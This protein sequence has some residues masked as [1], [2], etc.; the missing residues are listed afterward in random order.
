MRRPVLVR[1]L[2]LAPLALLVLAPMT[3]CTS[4]ADAG[5]GGPIT[6]TA[7]DSSCQLSATTADTGN[8]TF[9]VTN[10]GTKTTEFYLY[11]EGNR[12]MGE[13][14]NVSPGLTRRLVVEVP[15]AGAYTTAC[16]PGMVGEGVRGTFT[17]TGESRRQVDA[18]TKLADA[19]A[20]YQ[21]Y[22]AT[23]SDALVAKTTEFTDAV[24]AG[25]VEQAKA[26]YPVA[27]TFW[28]RIEPVAEKFGELDAL[29]DGRE[30]T[31]APGQ[32]LTGWHR[33]ERDLWQD[34]L[35]PDSSAMADQLLSNVTTVVAEAK[36]VE[37][38]PL[39][40]ANGAKELLDE[41]ATG[42]V[43]GE[44]DR[45]SHTDLWDFRANVEGSQAAINAL[46]P[47]LAERAPELLPKLDSRFAAVSQA[48]NALA[49]GD[50][51]V[52]YDTLTPEQVKTLSDKVDAL[53][54]PLSTVSGVVATQ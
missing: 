2:A 11:A 12:V 39:D 19:T 17:V 49:V 8:M 41:V 54:E 27:R 52:L 53:A 35:Q 40:L 30:D 4:K 15:D 37:L 36:T 9:E 13:V 51:Y 10:S 31:L 48:L 46:R 28:E 6:V 47:V 20:S 26:L 16:K 43:T 21:R 32:P 5:A 18:D 14:E 44:E 29:T 3:A 25:Q 34:G 22:V 7:N 45:Y 50:G 38:T 33:L 23:Q 42:K 1:R 24:E